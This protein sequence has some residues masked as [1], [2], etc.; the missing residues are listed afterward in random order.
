[1]PPQQIDIFINNTIHV[2]TAAPDQRDAWRTDLQRAKAH[3]DERG[4]TDDSAFIAALLAIVDGENPQLRSDS[5]FLP[6]L[7][8]VIDR[9]VQYDP[10]VGGPR[11]LPQTVIQ[12]I[13][14]ATATVMTSQPDR[15]A[16]WRADVQT[17]L[18]RARGH[19][20]PLDEAFFR[21]ILGILNGEQPVLPPQNPYAGVVQQ[22][23][24]YVIE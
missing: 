17:F 24:D 11:L 14:S 21:A 15:A 3:A 20:A 16:S 23:V 6:A 1:M 5:P 13:A 2:M 8:I 19:H 18:E 9:L 22:I 7:Q 4:A 10:E 12:D